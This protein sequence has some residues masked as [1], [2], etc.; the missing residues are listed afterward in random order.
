MTKIYGA[1][2]DLIELEGDIDDEVDALSKFNTT[3]KPFIISFDDNTKVR[4]FYLKDGI[5]KIEL[6]VAGHLFSKI[7]ECNGDKYSDELIMKDGL[8]SFTVEVERW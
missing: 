8:K 3:E 1:S 5:W 4:I 2:D 6:M 7:E